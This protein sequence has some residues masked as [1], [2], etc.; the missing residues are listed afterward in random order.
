LKRDDQILHKMWRHQRRDGAVLH[1]L[2]GPA[3]CR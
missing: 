3:E 2:S 1:E